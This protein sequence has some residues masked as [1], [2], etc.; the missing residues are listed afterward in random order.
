MRLRHA[1]IPLA[2]LAAGILTVAWGSTARGVCSPDEVTRIYPKNGQ[3]K[4]PRDV[5]LVLVY[6]HL[7]RANLR[8]LLAR[9]PVLAQEGGGGRVPLEIKQQPWKTSRWRLTYTTLGLRPKTPLAANTSYRLVWPAGARVLPR[10]KGYS[11]KTG[12]RSQAAILVKPSLERPIFRSNRRGCG[13]HRT[14]SLKITSGDPTGVRHV[15]LAKKKA[16]LQAERPRLVAEIVDVGRP[17]WLSIGAW[18]CGGSYRFRPRQRL[19]GQVRV[20]APNGSPGPWSAPFLLAADPAR[21]GTRR[22]CPPN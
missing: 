1:A 22:I 2:A 11:F 18:T 17:G 21:P 8:R 9:P 13:F 12:A 3:T 16:H 14:F 15:R 10:L 7:T 19:F 20:Y 5:Q 4:V 6:G